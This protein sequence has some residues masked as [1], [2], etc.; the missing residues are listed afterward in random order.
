MA[1]G[2][3]RKDG[4]LRRTIARHFAA[5]QYDE[6]RRWVTRTVEGYDAADPQRFSTLALREEWLA[7]V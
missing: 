7:R 3:M 2:R 1:R 5:V 4:R 6:L